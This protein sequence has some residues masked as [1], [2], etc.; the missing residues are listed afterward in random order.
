[1]DD[2]LDVFCAQQY[3]LGSKPLFGALY[4]W[5]SESFLLK[6]SSAHWGEKK[7]VVS[8]RT[9]LVQLMK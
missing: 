5:S 3:A 8:I 4:G 6:M 2:H 9:R 7:I 1:M